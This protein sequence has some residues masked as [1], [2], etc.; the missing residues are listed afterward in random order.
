MGRP[1]TGRIPPGPSA[2]AGWGF[3]PT[4]LTNLRRG[5]NRFLA[6][7]RQ[8]STTAQPATRRP[9]APAWTAATQASAVEDRRLRPQNR[10]NDRRHGD[11]S[12]ALG[13]A[14]QRSLSLLERS[15]ASQPVPSFP[16]L[17]DG[18]TLSYR[19]KLTGALPSPGRE[20]RWT[21]SV[22]GKTVQLD[23]RVHASCRRHR[24]PKGGPAQPCT[25]AFGKPAVSY[26]GRLDRRPYGLEL[27]LS[28]EQPSDG[29]PSEL[30]LHCLRSVIG[31]LPAGASLLPGDACK[32]DGPPP[33]WQPATPRDVGVWH[34]AVKDESTALGMA[35]KS[36]VRWSLPPEPG[37]VGLRQQRLRRP[38]APF[39]CPPKA[40]RFASAIR[41]AN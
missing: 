10:R 37:S 21:L 4:N 36:S 7:V 17:V 19:Q 11:P 14:G 40:A 6:E 16:P 15:S 39:A 12:R 20:L 27:W 3:S 9:R 13:C 33:R 25:Q 1:C 28:T 18:T 23:A 24:L 2:A 5:G 34:C 32:G 41:P 35:I 26:R 29:F 22:R 8:L 38:R 30:T 31:V